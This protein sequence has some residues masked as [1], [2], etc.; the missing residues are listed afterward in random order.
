[1]FYQN[2]LTITETAVYL[3][4][5]KRS[6]T[7]ERYTQLISK[8]GTTYLVRTLYTYNGLTERKTQWLY[9][10][11]KNGREIFYKSEPPYPMAKNNAR[12]QARNQFL[13]AIK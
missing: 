9:K 3:Y 1:V 11:I 2:N 13:K 7:M 6:Q 12:Q 8:K 5:V 4:Q 10:V